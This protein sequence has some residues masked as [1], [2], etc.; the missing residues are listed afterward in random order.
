MNLEVIT[1]DVLQTQND[2]DN[3][4]TITNL[5]N[6][7]EALSKK[8]DSLKDELFEDLRFQ[9]SPNQLAIDE[10]KVVIEKKFNNL[11][12]CGV[13]PGLQPLIISYNGK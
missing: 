13:V 8:F 10:D 12:K 6:K 5:T 9:I 2:C 7:L 11:D 4:V 3:H 1:K